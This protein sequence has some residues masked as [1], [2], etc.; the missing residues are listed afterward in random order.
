[1]LRFL[2]FCELPDDEAKGQERQVYDLAF[3]EALPIRSS[4]IGALR[5]GQVNQIEMGHLN[6][7]PLVV[8]VFIR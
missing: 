5:P 8:V 7:P 1:M 2:L 4:L 6:D 3:L